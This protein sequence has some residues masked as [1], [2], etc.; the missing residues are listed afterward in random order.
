MSLAGVAEWRTEPGHVDPNADALRGLVGG[1][2]HR[3]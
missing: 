2:P 3:V 1:L